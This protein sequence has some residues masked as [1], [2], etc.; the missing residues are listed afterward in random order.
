MGLVFLVVTFILLIVGGVFLIRNI[1]ANHVPDAVLSGVEVYAQEQKFTPELRVA[2]SYAIEVCK[3][4]CAKF[5]FKTD[6]E[7]WRL[8]LY[9]EPARYRAHF[10]SVEIAMQANS[11]PTVGDLYIGVQASL[12]TTASLVCHELAHHIY[13]RN[14]Y[15]R[16]TLHDNR[17]FWEAVDQPMKMGEVYR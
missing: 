16:Q 1:K 2:I 8:N 14:T 13:W 10:G 11:L 3:V 12:E 9:L 5:G 17:G 7:P 15:D 4:R 6:L